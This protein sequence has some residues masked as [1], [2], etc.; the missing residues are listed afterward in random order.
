MAC[1]QCDHG[2]Y[3]VGRAVPHLQ[4]LFPVPFSRRFTYVCTTTLQVKSSNLAVVYPFAFGCFR[5]SKTR[6][7][8]TSP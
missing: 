5:N 6:S 3:D 2:D 1:G 8:E 7:V 4:V